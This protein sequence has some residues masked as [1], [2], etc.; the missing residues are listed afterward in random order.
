[1]VVLED[2]EAVVE[3]MG[4]T[5]LE[6]VRKDSGEDLKALVED[7]K[8]LEE[9]RKDL[10]EGLKDLGV[11]GLRMRTFLLDLKAPKVIDTSVYRKFYQ[12]H[13][14]IEFVIK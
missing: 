7:L 4:N 8:D 14:T 12:Q 3:M 5:G 10:G 9:D 1:M 6:E 2:T 11:E 13:C